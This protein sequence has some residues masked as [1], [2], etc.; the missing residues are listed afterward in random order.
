MRGVMLDARPHALAARP[1][2]VMTGPAL[3]IRPA[4]LTHL[5]PEDCAEAAKAVEAAYQSGLEDGHQ[6][7]YEA[8]K[9]MALEEARAVEA[10]L[11]EACELAAAE[12][13]K[14]GLAQGREEARTAAFQAEALAKERAD[15]LLAE[16]LERLDQFLEG[17]A[18]EGARRLEQAEEDLVAFGHETV[19]RILGHQA[20]QP[21][22]LRAMVNGLLAQ[23][24]HRAQLAVHVHPDDF[25]ALTNDREPRDTG[26]RWV[27][28]KT[29]QLGGVL[30]RSPEGSLDARL[31]TQI[32]SLR[33][34]LLTVRRDR[35]NAAAHEASAIN[36]D[37]T[38]A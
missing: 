2:R 22:S 5:T 31:E 32:A 12:A 11:A 37:G 1:G 8:A 10:A 35:A 25:D 33:N 17:L 27:A 19:C 4:A 30:L 26:W 18:V 9:A 28:D 20:A 34:A 6:R 24:G 13:R 15:Q 23:H 14:H 29:V 21:E 38:A 16:R 36:I 3:Q 7:G